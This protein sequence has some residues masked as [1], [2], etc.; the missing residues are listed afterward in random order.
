MVAARDSPTTTR[1]RSGDDGVGYDC[2]LSVSCAEE[3]RQKHSEG[4]GKGGLGLRR[5]W[6]GLL[7]LHASVKRVTEGNDRNS[8][9]LF[10]S[11]FFSCSHFSFLSFSFSLHR[12]R[13]CSRVGV[14][15]CLKQ[16]GPQL[17]RD[18]RGHM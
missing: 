9:L 18:G 8:R 17:S 13:E 10:P 7:G 12:F 16:R 11:L 14:V 5:Q 3:W 6:R 4:T 15:R 1:N 2:R